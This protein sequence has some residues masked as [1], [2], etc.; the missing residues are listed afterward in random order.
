MPLMESVGYCKPNDITVEKKLFL[1]F[2]CEQCEH[3]DIILLTFFG[4]NP[5]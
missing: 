3:C 2:G 1:K 5:H 4:S